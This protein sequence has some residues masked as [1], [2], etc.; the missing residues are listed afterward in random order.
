MRRVQKRF[1][2]TGA[3]GLVALLAAGASGHAVEA[4]AKPRI[5]VLFDPG[6]R[7]A[8]PDL[9]KV[10]SIRFLTTDDYPPFH[11]TL[12]DGTLTG[13]DVDLARAICADLKIACTIQPRRFDTLVAQIKERKDDALIAAIADTPASRADLD[14]TAPYYTT[15]ARF[16][17]KT[18][19][20]PP[21]APT[22]AALA[23]RRV[24]V[25]AGTAH[26]AYLRA[27]FGRA[28]IVTFA[29][30]AALRG[31]LKAGKVDVAF[32]DGISL[33]LW[34]NGTD[35]AGCCRFQGGPFTESHY[36]GDGVSIAVAKG[37]EVLRAALDEELA[38]LTADGT[39]A[40]LYL[41]YF[42]IG[43]Y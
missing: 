40:D 14:F 1:R 7:L 10:R 34:L 43:F 35:A 39:Y 41:K 18:S 31:A 25:E 32:G 12:A 28:T 19:A 24:G 11:F 27:F 2:A 16:V 38:K 37:N 30:Q 23:G 22:P 33:A 3:L 15:P 21:E 13:F 20:T 36:F 17:T 8:K 26:E 29:D 42:P 6:A 9:D 4:P 5:P